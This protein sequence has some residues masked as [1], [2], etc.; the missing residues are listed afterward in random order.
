M[1]NFPDPGS[2]GAL[3]NP[4]LAGVPSGEE[5]L[6]EAGAVALDLGGRPAPSAAQLPAAL[7][8]ARC[9]RAHGFSQFPDPL[10]TCGPGFTLGRGEYFPDISTTELAP[11]PAF[12]QAAKACGV[13]LPT[14]PP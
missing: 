8:F 14:G 5:S 6:C 1:P 10:T 7:G 11:S 12:R 3:P 4:G 13:Q 2:N 9:M